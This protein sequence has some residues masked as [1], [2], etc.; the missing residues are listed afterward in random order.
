[1]EKCPLTILGK[2]YS[3]CSLTRRCDS[4]YLDDMPSVPF[5]ALKPPW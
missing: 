1:M 4:R 3:G 5:N 2:S